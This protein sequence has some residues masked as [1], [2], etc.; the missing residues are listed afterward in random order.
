MYSPVPFVYKTAY[1]DLNEFF[2]KYGLPT[3][4]YKVK[5]KYCVTNSNEIQT[6]EVDKEFEIQ[7]TSKLNAK[8]ITMPD[9]YVL[10]LENPDIN[11][12]ESINRIVYQFTLLNGTVIEKTLSNLDEHVNTSNNIIYTTSV[13]S[14]GTTSYFLGLST[15]TILTSEI[16][17]LEIRFYS[18]VTDESLI[19][20]Y[21][22]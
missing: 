14:D 21:S 12:K 16:R 1:L 7:N 3:A 18:D 19:T 22:K 4:N 11:M 20:M 9:S 6:F 2:T 5:F 17:S 10:M 15:G 13:N 8:I